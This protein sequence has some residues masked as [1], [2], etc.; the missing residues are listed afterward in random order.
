MKWEKIKRLKSAVNK[1]YNTNYLVLR[2]HTQTWDKCLRITR[3]VEIFNL[4]KRPIFWKSWTAWS[5]RANV[6][7]ALDPSCTFI[8]VWQRLLHDVHRGLPASGYCY[9]FNR[10]LR[11]FEVYPCP[12][13]LWFR[14]SSLCDWLTK[15][16]LLSQPMRS[17]TKTNR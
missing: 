10:V 12:S 16:A 6:F 9:D 3:I 11:R 1:P 4:C 8:Y 14:F 17:K 15:L 13:L 5:S 2:P 7:P